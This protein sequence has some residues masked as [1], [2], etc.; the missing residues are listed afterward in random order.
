MILDHELEFSNAQVVTATAPSANV[1]DLGVGRG[2]GIG[3]EMFLHVS[4]A[5]AL[6][7]S[8]AATL[9]IQLQQSVDEAFT[10]PEVVSDLGTVTKAAGVAGYEKIF[11]LPF[12]LTKRYARL[13]YTVANGPLTAG[14]VSSHIIDGYQ[15]NTHYAD[16]I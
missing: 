9:Q 3:S 15:K 4:L 1:I 7:A 2:V 16:G 14:K 8:G 11:P 6:A 10:S 5:E 13:L 12:D